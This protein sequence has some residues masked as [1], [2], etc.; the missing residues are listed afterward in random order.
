MLFRGFLAPTALVGPARYLSALALAIAAI[1]SSGCSTTQTKTSAPV[2]STPLPSVTIDNS[3]QFEQET[4]YALITAE[5]ALVRERYDLG[6]GNYVQQARDTGD[7]N[8]AARAAR[9]ARILSAHE[10]SLEMAELWSSLDPGDREARFILIAEYIH[11]KRFDEAFDH[12]KAMM[13]AGHAA[14]FEDIAI[15]AAQ[16]ASRQG[17][18]LNSSISSS[19]SSNTGSSAQAAINAKPSEATDLNAL[20]DQYRLLLQEYPDNSELLVGYSIL[21]QATMQLEPALTAINKATDLAPNSTRAVY[22]Q[23]RVLS[24]LRRDQEALIVY[25]KL[26]DLQP[27]NLRVRGR[28][29]HLL[30][31]HDLDLALK[32][33]QIL[34][35]LNPDSTDILLNLALLQL[36]A[37]QYT[38]AKA[39]F[40]ALIERDAHLSTA[41][42][43]LGDI[44]ERSGDKAGALNHYIRV[45]QG[46]RYVEASSRAADLI[47]NVESFKD[48]LVFLS[49]RRIAAEPNDRESLFLI[50][51]ETLVEQ[52]MSSRAS[53]TYTMALEEFPDSAGLRYS[54]AMYRAAIGEIDGAVSDFKHVLK[55][56]PD[57][58]ATL[59]ALGFTLLDQT[60]RID[61]A[62]I[63]IRKAYAINST[64][65]AII[66]SLGWLEFKLGNVDKAIELLSQALAG[67][68]DGEIAAH[69]GE[70]HWQAGQQRKAKSVWRQGLKHSPEHP[71]IINT[72]KRLNI[73][74][75]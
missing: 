68:M 46:A 60:E 52:G 5:L 32:Q 15:D 42:F 57:S 56:A 59:N 17:S 71:A 70:A 16:H 51:A 62:A 75:P 54:R 64:D 14:G 39:N 36:D 8:I 13:Q 48:A 37:K 47:S 44:A 1:T 33:Y 49:S 9:I 65:P 11:A 23:F 35:D 3:L 74:K 50:E 2:K 24:Q 69:L 34:H 19:V 10:E 40:N 31:D 30:L 21:L 27:D 6:L 45:K 58:A 41:E 38:E 12:A 26:V 20:S 73:E 4:L 72:L 61:E 7:V 53:A 25:Q 43:G 22:Q 55:A 29:A 67:F 28:Y 66:D 18:E 63:Y